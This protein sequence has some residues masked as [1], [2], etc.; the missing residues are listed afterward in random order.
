MRRTARVVALVV[1]L[2]GVS[3]AGR[4]G[5]H[6]FTAFWEQSWCPIPLVLILLGL[7]GL[8]VGISP[9]PAT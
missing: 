5:T 9:S 6:G 7:A 1:L 2:L 8:F 3:W 4:E